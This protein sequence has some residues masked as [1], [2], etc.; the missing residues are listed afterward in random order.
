MREMIKVRANP[1][2]LCP[3]EPPR[4]TF[5]GYRDAKPGEKSDHEIPASLKGESL[6]KRF[7][8]AGNVEV[9]NTAYYRRAIGRG[10][11]HRADD[12]APE[13]PS[14]DDPTPADSE[15]F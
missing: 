13:Q 1:S 12:P 7:V 5:V 10:D 8:L 15:D 4:R 3:M 9:P 6:P 11:I 14:A 2:R